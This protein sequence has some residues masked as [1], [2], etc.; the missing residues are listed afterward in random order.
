MKESEKEEKFIGK[1][2]LGTLTVET[3]TTIMKFKQEILEKLIKEKGLQEELKII[4]VHDMRLR[5]AKNNDLGPICKDKTNDGEDCLIHEYGLW[6]NKEFYV[7][8]AEH[9]N[10][11]YQA[12]E[13]SV[14]NIL[15][16]EWKGDTWEFGPIHE[17]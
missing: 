15:V 6:D 3:G 16:R 9:A 1:R 5:N 14:Y 13:G 7:Q 12:F 2:K 17:V 11:L 10:Q 8:K 4:E